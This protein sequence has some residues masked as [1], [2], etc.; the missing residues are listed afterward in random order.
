MQKRLSRLLL[1]LIYGSLQTVELFYHCR[2]VEILTYPAQQCTGEALDR[3]CHCVCLPTSH[4]TLSGT[5]AETHP[6]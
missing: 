6:S 5:A 1:S 2:T 3:L 4:L